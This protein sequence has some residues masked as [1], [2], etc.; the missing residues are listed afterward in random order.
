MNNSVGEGGERDGERE[1]GDGER[2]FFLKKDP[3]TEDSHGPSLHSDP[4][5]VKLRAKM[6]WF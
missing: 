5:I 1:R 6:Y 3:S 2:V 4:H